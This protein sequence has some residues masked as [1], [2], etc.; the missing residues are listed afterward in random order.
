MFH[1]K[2]T[3]AKLTM[4]AALLLAA[5]AGA[6]AQ[7]PT[8][9]GLWQKVD[10]DTKKPISWFLFIERNGTYEGII[11]KFFLRPGDDPNQVCSRCTDDRKNQPVL[12]LPL[13]RGMK[14]QGLKYEDGNIVDPR[15]GKVY[16]AIMTLS[17]DGQVL[18]V[19][20]YLGITLFGMDEVW[21]RMPDS[22]MAQVDR[23]VLA[24]YMPGQ[25]PATSGKGPPS[26]AKSK[27]QK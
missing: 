16:S 27:Q 2:M 7:E 21:H 1:V 19:R 15:D 12:G 25:Q 14:R 11:A 6:V 20:G 9:L 10:E 23:T 18:T 22:A 17:Q 24:K 5:A 13:V 26:G 4:A 8:V 3:L